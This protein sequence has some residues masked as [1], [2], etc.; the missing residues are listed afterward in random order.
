MG[1]PGLGCGAGF[2]ISGWAFERIRTYD[3][4]F[5]SSILGS[6]QLVTSR[7]GSCTSRRA[8]AL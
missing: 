8:L 5:G 1:T 7:T 3:E 6:M 2:R 4:G